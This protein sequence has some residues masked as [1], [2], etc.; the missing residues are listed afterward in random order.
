[1]LGGRATA[2]GA[3]RAQ[4]ENDRENGALVVDTEAAVA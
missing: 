1:V 2:P 3:L 4:R